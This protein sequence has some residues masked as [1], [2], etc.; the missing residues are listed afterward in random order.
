MC[1]VHDGPRA[2]RE[3]RSSVVSRLGTT[4]AARRSLEGD[5][6]VVLSFPGF[7]GERGWKWFPARNVANRAATRS[8]PPPSGIR[9]QHFDGLHSPS[10][11]NPDECRT[12]AARL[13]L[14]SA[15]EEPDHAQQRLL[16]SCRER[17]R[18][19]LAIPAV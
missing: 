7:G 2:S 9:G 4:L 3:Q 1:L 8:V 14:R 13:I 5:L 6:K 12:V 15:T 11:S 16:R 10:H 18:S 19:A 17:P